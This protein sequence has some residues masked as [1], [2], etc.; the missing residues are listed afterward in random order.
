MMFVLGVL[1][2][3]AAV[4]AFA[5]ILETPRKYVLHDGIVG[6]IGGF[7]YLLSIQMGQDVVMA[8]FLSALA[9]ALMSHTFARIFKAPVTIF[10]IAGILPTVPGAGM[11]RIVYYLIAN[12]SERSSYYL[13]QTLEVAGVIAL[14]IFIMDSIFK[15][16]IKKTES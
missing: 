7:V 10:L 6:G 4:S 5:I 8:S 15:V 3:F 14:A 2:C 1:G 11:Y 9:I 12:D 16:R 13:V